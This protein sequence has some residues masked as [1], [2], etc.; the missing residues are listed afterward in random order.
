MALESG[1]PFVG[2]RRELELIKS[3]MNA[4]R[5][6]QGGTILLAGDT[7]VGKTRLANEALR[8]AADEGMIVLYGAFY[9]QEGQLPYQSFVEAINRYLAA[10]QLV[11]GK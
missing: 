9:E 4:G 1:T 7:G 5:R 11:S 6:G 3:E 10:Q 8:A 2:R